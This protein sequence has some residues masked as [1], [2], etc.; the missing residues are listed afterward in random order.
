[1][2][3]IVKRPDPSRTQDLLTRLF[4]VLCALICASLLMAALGYHPL[5]VFGNIFIGSTGTL[6]RI[7][8]TIVK[9]I[10]LA[11]LS[12]GVAVAFKMKFWNIGAEGQF[13]MGA[14]A[15][16]WV[17]FNSPPADVTDAAVLFCAAMLFAAVGVE[18]PP[19]SKQSSNKEILLH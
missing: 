6:H 12:L 17:A 15:A 18:S 14:M 1:M 8:E 3:Q 5:Q 19:F 13:Y 16:A 10:P 7:R 11:T 2:I 4:A 9:T